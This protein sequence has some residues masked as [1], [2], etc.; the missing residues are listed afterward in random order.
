LVEIEK[1]IKLVIDI[2]GDWAI[3]Q[4]NWVYL[5]G[6]FELE[7]I[8][9]QLVQENKHFISIDSYYRNNIKLFEQ[10]PQAYRVCFRENFSGQL[11]K[12]NADCDFIRAGLTYFLEKKRN[13][14]PRLYFLSNEELIDIF[15]R[16]PDL[17]DEL[18]ENKNKAFLINLFE[19]IDQVQFSEYQEI[20]HMISR[21]GERMK[22]KHDV[23]T[24]NNAIETWLI[25]L[26]RSM[27]L[28][29]KDYLFLTFEQLDTQ[30]LEDWVTQWPAQTTFLSSQIWFTKKV[31]AIYQGTM[32][33][34]R[35]LRN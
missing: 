25:Q 3:F 29:V 32:E 34:E 35:Y 20:T 16:G 31:E 14:F 22:L 28:T 5:H 19:G 13:K 4:K 18:M 30:D 17:I 6:I 9:R 10:N 1:T 24:F 15:G 27:I 23:I 11:Q 26:E 21:E 33:R 12:S 2:I 7:E 8:S